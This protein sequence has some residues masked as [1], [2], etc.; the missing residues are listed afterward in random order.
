MSYMND[1]HVIMR[2]QLQ[3]RR[4]FRPPCIHMP[5]IQCH[6]TSSHH[7]PTIRYRRIVSRRSHKHNGPCL[8]PATPPSTARP[9]GKTPVSLNALR[10]N[11]SKAR[12]FSI[13]RPHHSLLR[14]TSHRLRRNHNLRLRLSKRRS[15]VVVVNNANTCHSPSLMLVNYSNQTTHSPGSY[16]PT[17]YYSYTSHTPTLSLNPSLLHT[18]SLTHSQPNGPVAGPSTPSKSSLTSILNGLLSAKGLPNSPSQIVRTIM[19]MGPSEVELSLRLQV[20]LK[21]R[22][23]AGNDFYQAWASNLEAMEII[24][25]WLR[26]TVASKTGEWDET[27]M[28]LL[29]VRCCS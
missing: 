10:Y 24:R 1:N 9:A 4:V 18:S 2:Y 21:I 8:Y 26:A 17:T 14:H 16:A 3:H 11:M 27:I 28:P 5:S 22:D 7:T 6:L 19:T 20:L 12:F 23:C 15:N 25:D 13:P 29:H